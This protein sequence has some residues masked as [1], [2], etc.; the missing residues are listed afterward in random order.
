VE[1]NREKCLHCGSCAAVCGTGALV[2]YGQKVTVEEIL[3][4]ALS[5][6][7]YYS[8]SGGGIT[9]SGGEPCLQPEFVSQLYEQCQ[10]RGLHTT[11]DTCGYISQDSLTAVLR[12]TDLVLYDI[13]HMDSE[14]HKLLTGVENDLILKNIRVVDKMNIPF[15]IRFPLIR[16]IN[17]DEKNIRAA[18]KFA[19]G[20]RNIQGFD[21]LPY[22]R[23]GEPKYATLDRE[24]T[25]PGL[26]QSSE[27]EILH[28]KKIIESYNLSCE[29]GG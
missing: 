6:R 21:I 13:K 18:A 16:T 25:L 19:I 29:I 10:K 28:M 1:I 15:R 26:Q 5:D 17:D 27:M 14:R 22:H 7:T 2:R 23:Y 11:L 8:E 12:Y 4:E 20:L 3:A 9:A 24:Y